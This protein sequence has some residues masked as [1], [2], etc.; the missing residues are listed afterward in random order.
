M[1]EL[2]FIGYYKKPFDFCYITDRMLIESMQQVRKDSLIFCDWNDVNPDLSCSNSFDLQN[3]Y[4][5]HYDILT[6]DLMVILEVPTKTSTHVSLEKVTPLLQRMA[7]M[8][9]PGINSPETFIKFPDKSYLF[10]YSQLPF[11]KTVYANETTNLETL[12]SRFGEE[13]ILKPIDTDGGYGIRKLV[14]DPGEVKRIIQENKSE[15]PFLIQEFL[16]E[17]IDGERSLFFFNKRFKY[18][19]LKKPRE[20]EF[21]SNEDHVE[22]LTRY[23]PTST[24]LWVAENAL[25]VLNSPSLLERVDMSSSGKIIEMTLDCPGLYLV[26]AGVN[27][28]IGMWFYELVDTLIN[29]Q[30][31]TLTYSI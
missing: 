22:S 25:Q 19:M 7:D 11:P 12:L 1:S 14:N 29:K 27:K 10:K 21:R 18:A 2:C 23:Y 31:S 26:E 13:I 6:S 4:Y 16:P 30:L 24:E 8:K 3:Q 9:L 5:T 20:G 15:G 17:I 28:E